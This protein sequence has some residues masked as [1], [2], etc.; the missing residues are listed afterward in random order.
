[1]LH[2]PFC[3]KNVLDDVYFLLIKMENILDQLCFQGVQRRHRIYGGHYRSASFMASALAFA[4]I[5]SEASQSTSK[6]AEDIEML[7]R[8]LNEKISSQKRIT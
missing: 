8:I 1:M 3:S 5:S 2:I 4:I 7:T 6:W